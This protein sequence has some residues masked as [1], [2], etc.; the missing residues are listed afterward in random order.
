MECV[1]AVIHGSTRAQLSMIAGR[2]GAEL[3]GLTKAELSTK[4]MRR[5]RAAGRA[6]VHKRRRG[7][8]NAAGSPAP[9]FRVA[10]LLQQACCVRQAVKSRVVSHGRVA[11]KCG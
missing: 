11:T 3:A 2:S 5:A 4:R 7:H 10:Q 9:V 8:A 1:D 6:T